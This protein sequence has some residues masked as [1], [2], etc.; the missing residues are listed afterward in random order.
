MHEAYFFVL[1]EPGG[2]LQ[3][4]EFDIVTLLDG[5]GMEYPKFEELLQPYYNFATSNGLSLCASKALYRACTDAGMGGVARYC[6]TF[7]DRPGLEA[8]FHNWLLTSFSTIMPRIFLR[9][10]TVTCEG[11]AK[12]LASRWLSD[13]EEL[14]ANGLKPGTTFG[15]VVA[16]KPLAI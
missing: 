7:M 14:L 13:L 5:N 12:Q 1:P 6:P 2:Y 9:T 3:W 11:A 16:Q 4:V 8:K 10:G 15:I